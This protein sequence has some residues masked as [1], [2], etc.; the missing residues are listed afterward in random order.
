LSEK[1]KAIEASRIVFLARSV[2][3]CLYR[4][5]RIGVRGWQPY[6]LFSNGYKDAKLLLEQLTATRPVILEKI[7]YPDTVVTR[8]RNTCCTFRLA[9][10]QQYYFT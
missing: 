3:S 5:G 2:I 9:S 7:R 10:R 8:L 6:K 4:R 1:K